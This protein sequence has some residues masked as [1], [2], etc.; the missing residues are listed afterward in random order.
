MRYRVR[1]PEIA[2]G[3]ALFAIAGMVSMAGTS[4]SYG[5]Y[6]L[7][8]DVAIATERQYAEVIADGVVE[9]VRLLQDHN[10]NKQA[11]LDRKLAAEAEERQRKAAAE[12]ASRA[13]AR[14]AA[15]KKPAARTTTKS[16]A[17]TS[18][19][20]SAAW[21]ASAKAVAV[22]QCE[23]RGNPLSVSA[24][25]KYQGKWQMDDSFWRSYG[26]LEFAS[27]PQYATEAQQDEVAYRGWLARGWQPWSWAGGR[28]ARA[29]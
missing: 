21:A 2:A 20:S 25:G 5:S 16:A 17:Q 13:A 6:E 14:A 9:E 10:D 4:G 24:S 3:V 18:F 29:R 8:K 7:K 12:E 26:G 15:L 1:H 27:D 11:E 22:A 19:T 23:S 28:C